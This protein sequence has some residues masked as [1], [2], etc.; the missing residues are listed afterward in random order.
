MPRLMPRSSCR[1]SSQRYCDSEFCWRGR[2]ETFQKLLSLAV[3]LQLVPFVYMFGA[4]VKFA[5]TESVPKGQ[6]ENDPVSGR[7]KRIPDDDPRHRV[8][9]FSRPADHVAVAIRIMDVRGTL[10]FIGSGR[11]FLFCLRPPQNSWRATFNR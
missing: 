11:I 9:I 5:V 6:Y 2:A 10:F 1:E 4:L 7:S 8:G 3:V